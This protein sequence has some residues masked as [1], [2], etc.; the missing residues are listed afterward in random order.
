M[1]A[2][3]SPDQDDERELRN[4][5]MVAHKHP[6]EWP[7][8][9]D[10]VRRDS[11]RWRPLLVFLA[12]HEHSPVLPMAL[13]LLDL[14]AVETRDAWEVAELLAALPGK[15]SS[16]ANTAATLT[17]RL[18]DLFPEHLRGADLEAAK[19]W[20]NLSERCQDA[21][22]PE[23]ALRCAQ[24][25][26]AVSRAVPGKSPATQHVRVVTLLTLAKRQAERG[27]ADLALEAANSAFELAS[28]LARSGTRPDLLLQAQAGILL[29]NRYSAVGDSEHAVTATSRA[30][31]LFA[32]CEGDEN[33]R[34]DLGLL[35]HSL[36]SDLTRQGR[37]E[38]A[39]PLSEC[40]ERL[41]R[42]LAG[43]NPDEYEEY[44]AAAAYNYAIN[45]TQIGDLRRAY[46]LSHTA[47]ERMKPLVD[48]QLL[49]FGAEY[50]AYLLGHSDAAAELG[51]FDEALDFARQAIL[52]ARRLGRRQGLRD[53]YLEG[54]SYVN[55]FKLLYRLQRFP[56]AATAIR[57]ALRAFN[58]VSDKH[59]GATMERARS[60]RNL[61]EVQ[62]VTARPGKAGMAVR[63]A[64]QA[65]ARLTNGAASATEAMRLLESQCRTT[66]ANC[67][68]EAGDLDGAIQEDEASLKTR[69]ELF[70][71][72]SSVHRPDLAY[73]LM[74][75]ARRCLKA[76]R[77]AQAAPLAAEC[78]RHYEAIG[79][80]GDEQ[81]AAFFADALRVLADTQAAN[82]DM[83]GAVKQ[84]VRGIGLLR[85]RFAAAPD[86]WL[87]SLLPVCTRYV[88]LCGE[89][90]IEFEAALVEDVI[91]HALQSAAPVHE[92]G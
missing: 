53:W 4:W 8:I 73:C 86:L 66:L 39:L 46:D 10:L 71:G 25:A 54:Q 41:F 58:R 31:D 13:K 69:R 5:L 63:T 52:A 56:E 48:R 83:A 64:R 51:K 91:A 85:P 24:K 49:R 6:H 76:E 44:L 65:L 33:M 37:H 34:Y 11:K 12:T 26:V 70:A 60:L 77:L 90:G 29:A 79:L 23:D 42:I 50:T 21:N 92:H 78:V 55:Q 84:L 2:P 47:V 74:Q 1:K 36:A 72:S 22:R 80:D 59:P 82:G 89:A 7:G 81:T 32:Q 67:L 17:A 68:E 28:D 61:A 9:V 14:L 35:A 88:E 45:L 40:A 43:A 20:N 15:S 18:L 19:L 27:E 62:R 87:V 38:A 16:L 75:T 3:A 30:C 57:V